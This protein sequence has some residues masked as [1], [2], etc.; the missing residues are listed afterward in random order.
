VAHKFVIEAE[1]FGHQLSIT[2]YHVDTLT[3]VTTHLKPGLLRI[4]QYQLEFCNKLLN[5]LS[6]TA[7]NS[8]VLPDDKRLL[9]VTMP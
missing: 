5:R 4:N 6:E 8:S 3:V 7:P 2:P 9:T 1:Q